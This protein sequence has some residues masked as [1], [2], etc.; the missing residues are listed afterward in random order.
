MYLMFAWHSSHF[1]HSK[2][3]QTEA[4]AEVDAEAETHKQCS[5]DDAKN[6]LRISSSNND[7][8]NSAKHTM[9]VCS[10]LFIVAS[11]SAALDVMTAGKWII[12]ITLR[13]TVKFLSVIY[14]VI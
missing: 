10:N 11:I 6:V 3:K 8:R 7:N 12:L 1:N 13:V 2:R 9:S 4:A 14:L 5:W